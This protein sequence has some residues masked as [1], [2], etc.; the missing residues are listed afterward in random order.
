MLDF[1]KQ[2]LKHNRKEFDLGDV[3]A[4]EYED[5]PKLEDITIEGVP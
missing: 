2:S 5:Y 4:E 3:S 1:P